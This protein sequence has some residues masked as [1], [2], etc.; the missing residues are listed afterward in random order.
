MYNLLWVL[1]GISVVKH[2]VT[3]GNINKPLKALVQLDSLTCCPEAEASLTGGSFWF[4]W[5]WGKPLFLSHLVLP[6]LRTVSLGA[7]EEQGT[8]ILEL[9][10]GFH[11]LEKEREGEPVRVL[12]CCV[13]FDFKMFA[14]SRG[15]RD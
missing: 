10:R 14:K 8:P 5:W 2:S 7:V 13:I 11:A 12:Y 3:F 1:L 15:L 4:K 9:R 6:V